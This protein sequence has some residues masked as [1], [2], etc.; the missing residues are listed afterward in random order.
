MHTPHLIRGIALVLAGREGCG[1]T[2]LA[3]TVAGGKRVAEIGLPELEH[4]FSLGE[5]LAD[6]PE[7]LIVDDLPQRKTTLDLVNQILG[8]DVTVCPRKG[9]WPVRVPSPHLIFCTNQ[10][11]AAQ[12]LRDARRFHV[13]TLPFGKH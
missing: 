12:A 8:N 1:K 10:V 2:T 4:Q 3:R 9:R 7:V 5:V 6:E 13:V 11:A